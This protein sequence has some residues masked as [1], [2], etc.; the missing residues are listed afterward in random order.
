MVRPG[1][2][3]VNLRGVGAGW[4]VVALGSNLGDRAAHL[5]GARRGLFA[6]GFR[7]I[8]ASPVEQTVPLPGSAPG[9][10]PYLNQL[11]AARR[12]DLPLDAAGLLALG[13]A[14]ERA[15]GRRREVEARWGPR[16]L[17]VDLV[18]F[19]D[20]ILDA[21]G[22]SLPHPRYTER[23]FITGPLLAWWP[24]LRD[25]RTGTPLRPGGPV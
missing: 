2:E 9:Q 14:L 13:Q 17:D 3:T 19:G 11:L 7:W 23:P 21:P 8:L 1:A 18:L 15:A 22:L 25:P 10:G 20:L 5:E 6:G 4:V 24:G 12:S 16:P